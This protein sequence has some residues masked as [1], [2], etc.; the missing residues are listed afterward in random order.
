[1]ARNVVTTTTY[2][3]DIDGSTAAGTVSF[4]FDGTHYEI[5]LSK[6]NAAAFEKAMRPYLD[7]ARRVRNTRSRATSRRAAP[8]RDLAAIREWA[9]AN[10]YAVSSRGRIAGEVIDAYEQAR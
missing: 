9:T 5:D 4:A 7:A 3:D 8:T 6:R 10:G 1:M 2:T